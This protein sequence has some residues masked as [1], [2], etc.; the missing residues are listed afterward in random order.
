VA[1]YGGEEIAVILPETGNVEACLVAERFR[2]MV[3]AQPFTYT[4]P[5]GETITIPITISLGVAE[6]PGDALT[7]D[8]LVVAA[9]R[10]LYRAK[11]AGRNRVASYSVSRL[12]GTTHLVA[13]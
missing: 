7:P 1:R 11:R 2:S 8:A 3:A 9:D 5:G 12:T 13:R 6:L 4:P 10:A